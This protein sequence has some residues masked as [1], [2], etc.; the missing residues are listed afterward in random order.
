MTGRAT[1]D[2]LLRRAAEIR[3]DATALRDAPNRPQLIGGGARSFDWARLDRTV[4]A[5]AGRLKA[6]GFPTD[7]VIA[8]QFPL[9]SDGV[10][11]FLAIVRAGMIAAPLPLGW[12]RRETVAHLQR[13]GARAILTAGRAGPVDCADMMR[14]A[15]AETFSV[16]FVMSIG[17]PVLD[18]VV[19]LDDVFETTGAVERIETPRTA[20]AADHVALVTVDA[21]AEGHLAVPRSHNE[22]IAGGLA[23]FMAGVPDETSVFAATLALDAYAGIALQL[24]PWLMCGGMLVAHPPFAPRVYADDLGASRI[25]HAVLPVAA[26]ACLSGITPQGRPALRHLTLL[27]RRGADILLAHDIRPEA[28]AVDV[29]FGPG[30]AGL[31]RTSATPQA[32]GVPIGPDTF[33][34]GAGQAPVLVETRA[35]PAGTL[36][37]RGAMVPAFAFPPGAERGLPPFWST[38]A[39][40]FFDTG[41]P[42]TT[43]KASRALLIADGPEGVVAVGGR[44]FA[45]ADIRAAYAEAGGEIAP[46]LRADPVLGQR[47]SGIVGDGRAIVG[48]AG[49]LA[50]T[51]LTALGIPG[52]QRQAGPLPFED[53]RPPEQQP[54]RDPLTETQAALEQLLTMARAAIAR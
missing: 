1:L 28:V 6:L 53:T 9:G 2:G 52:G 41:L 22:V 11:A 29:F 25:S 18:G 26:A 7:S 49:R 23:A 5:L 8:T 48:L 24:V 27:A 3:P 15:A 12:G 19:P 32:G 4:D 13:L 31:T 30:E 36:A 40:G 51:G 42:V 54:A 45:E 46:V 47:V 38:D 16:R 10:V 50:E 20:N 37:L 34:T 33:A 44:R 21:T 35:S 39:E 43:D 17:T 14:F